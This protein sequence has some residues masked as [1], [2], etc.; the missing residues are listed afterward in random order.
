MTDPNQLTFNISKRLTKSDLEILEMFISSEKKSG[1]GDCKILQYDEAKKECTVIFDDPLVKERVLATRFFKCMDYYLRS[2]PNGYTNEEY[3][4]QREGLVLQDIKGGDLAIV[5]LYAEFLLPDNPIE[6]IQ[7]SSLFP[8]TYFIKYKEQIDVV[9][10]QQRYLKKSKLN[11]IEIKYYFAKST[12]TTLI[13]PLEPKQKATLM[14]QLLSEIKQFST[15]LFFDEHSSFFILQFQNENDLLNVTRSIEDFLT[16]NHLSTEY[17]Y[18]FDLFRGHVNAAAPIKR[19]DKTVQTES[20]EADDQQQLIFTTFNQSLTS[21]LVKNINKSIQLDSKKYSLLAS[22]LFNCQQILDDFNNTDLKFI[23][24]NCRLVLNNVSDQR[25]FEIAMK[26]TDSVVAK[27]LVLNLIS[28]YE[29]KR[30]QRVQIPISYMYHDGLKQI[31]SPLLMRA[32]G[33]LKHELERLRKKLRTQFKSEKCVH[34]YFDLSTHSFELTGY[35]EAVALLA[36]HLHEAL[37]KIDQAI[38]LKLKEKFCLKLSLSSDM[39]LGVFLKFDQIYFDDFKIKLAQMDSNVC[40]SLVPDS[41]I[42]NRKQPLPEP[43]HMTQALYEEMST[44]RINVEKFARN[45]LSKFGGAPVEAPFDRDSAEARTFYYDKNS[46]DI[47]WLDAR[48][49]IVFG[50]KEQ[51]ADLKERLGKIQLTAS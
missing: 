4:L 16:V 17:C 13:G 6:G 21:I 36:R 23:S 12:H 38:S 30:L 1:G 29:N 35:R 41:L 9:L 8:D 46:L 45:Y 32:F 24:P 26:P 31:S 19:E 27:N 14:P 3:A 39:R 15:S 28:D 40:V 42:I 49:L 20:T 2:S 7:A 44:W 34:A 10:M 43:A 5:E 33:Q 51:I 18:S 48:K 37:E 47:K 11:N 50:I 25:N 22:C